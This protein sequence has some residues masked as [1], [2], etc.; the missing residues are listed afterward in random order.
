MEKV[1]KHKNIYILEEM[2]IFKAILNLAIPS[3]LSM[4]INILYNLTDTFFI[5]QLK[6]PIAMAGVSIAL[7]L[8]TMQSAIAGIFGVGGASYLSRLLGKKDYNQAKETATIS[9]FSALII[10]L[11]VSI[12][13]ILTMPF[14][15]KAVGASASTIVPASQYM[16]WMFLGSP[17]VFVKFTMVQMIRGEGGA[18]YSM[19][20][21]F[22]GTG[23]NIIL[24]PLFIFVFNM[25]VAGAAIATV[26]GQGLAMLYYIWYYHSTHAVAV[27]GKKYLHFKWS[28]FKEI[29]YIGVPASLSQIM[30][31]VGNA[32]T[33]RLAASYGDASVASLGVASRVFSIPL[34]IFIGMAMGVQSLIGFNYGAGNYSR[35]KKAVRTAVIINLGLSVIFTIIFILFPRELIGIFI[36]NE[37]IMNIGR[38]VLEAYVWAI[39]FASVGMIFMNSLQAMGK[40]LPALIVSLSRQGLIYIP[41]LLIMNKFFGFNGLVYAMPMGDAFTTILSFIFVYHII[42]KLKTAPAAPISQEY[43]PF[44]ADEA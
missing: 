29:L 28:I 41:A 32:I 26:I 44:P 17:I 34:F 14:T 19:Y 30:M 16:L 24:D 15:L 42:Q 21:L 7:P 10:S 11:V 2:P 35:M 37:E 33:Y 1:K 6:D 9:L 40:A 3:M 12:V 38:K 20:G 13:G 4:L 23:A 36:H 18:K 5:G 22:I 31:S 39:P 27:P 25:G 8:F 43:I